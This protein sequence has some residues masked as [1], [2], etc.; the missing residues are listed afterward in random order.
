M[1]TPLNINPFFTKTPN[2]K[3]STH[4]KNLRNKQ[5][6]SPK[7]IK[8]KPPNTT[9]YNNYICTNQKTRNKFNSTPSNNNKPQTLIHTQTPKNI[10]TKNHNK[11]K[12]SLTPNDQKTKNNNNNNNNNKLKQNRK[13]KTT[14]NSLPQQ[15]PNKNPNQITKITSKQQTKTYKKQPLL[16]T[17][18]TFHSQLLLLL[19]GDIETNPG[20]MPNILQTHPPTHR[21]RCKNYFIECTIKLQPEYQHLAKQFSPIINITHPNHQDATNKYPYLSSYIHR[22]Q[23]HPPHEYYMHLLPLLVKK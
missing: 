20:P 13:C 2:D 8:Q 14:Y 11:Y 4:N 10:K 15:C 12:I 21:N 23:H 1:L 9:P 5:K 7:P 19:S 22:N 18:Y 6:R 3:P 17:S 16:F